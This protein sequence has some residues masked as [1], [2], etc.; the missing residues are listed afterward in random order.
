MDLFY[1]KNMKRFT[2]ILLLHS[3]L[4]LG[5]IQAQDY[6]S[7]SQRLGKL[8]SEKMIQSQRKGLSV[9]DFVN[10]EGNTT[11]L[12]SFLSDKIFVSITENKG[13]FSIINRSRLKDLLEENKISV[14]T[15]L[16]DPKTSAKLGKLVGIDVLVIG[17]ITKVGEFMDISIQGIDLAKAE[18]IFASSGR[19]SATKDIVDM[20][21]R[22]LS[23]NNANPSPGNKNTKSKPS[24]DESVSSLSLE[25]RLKDF[26]IRVKNVTQK[27]NKLTVAFQIN[28]QYDENKPVW[29]CVEQSGSDSKFKIRMNLEGKVLFPEIVVTNG[30][31]YTKNDRGFANHEVNLPRDLWINVEAIFLLDIEDKISF[32]S[33]L[34]LPLYNGQLFGDSPEGSSVYT[35]VFRNI[36]LSE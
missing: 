27:G 18:V 8:L 15:G 1:K 23:V 12:G 16:V 5:Y 26:K 4:F 36:Q 14:T 35:V 11:E 32:I 9:A 20:H 25:T 7:E 21:A 31:K 19:L 22:V 13:N 33:G 6:V 34:E 30:V 28:N 29:V 17:K 3:F 24:N 10:Q 2:L